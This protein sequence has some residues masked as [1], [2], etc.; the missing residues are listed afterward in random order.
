MIHYYETESP[1]PCIASIGCENHQGVI[2]IYTKLNDELI[3]EYLKILPNPIQ[4]LCS[5]TEEKYNDNKI[6]KVIYTPKTRVEALILVSLVRYLTGSDMSE[7][8]NPEK[9]I[10]QFIQLKDPTIEQTLEIVGNFN[11]NHFPWM[12]HKDYNSKY[13]RIKHLKFSDCWN[14]LKYAKKEMYATDMLYEEYLFRT[15]Q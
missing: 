10:K 8:K 11:H 2:G 14:A 1:V 9:N 7:Y 5:L 6:I 13:Q 3:T 4:K 12:Y 15:G